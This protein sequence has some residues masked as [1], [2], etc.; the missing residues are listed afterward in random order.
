MSLCEKSINHLL[1][2]RVYNVR[3]DNYAYCIQWT[4]VRIGRKMF[5]RGGNAGKVKR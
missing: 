3:M 2:Q 1:H 5:N 4:L